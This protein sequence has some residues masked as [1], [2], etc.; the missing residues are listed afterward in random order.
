[1]LG[2]KVNVRRPSTRC[3][4][5][6]HPPIAVYAYGHGHI[7]GNA[8]VTDSYSIINQLTGSAPMKRVLYF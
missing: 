4:Q 3:C 7:H 2:I 5:I 1:M 8:C 6:L